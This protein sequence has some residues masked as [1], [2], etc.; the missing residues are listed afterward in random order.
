MSVSRNLRKSM[1]LLQ[2]LF[3]I[4]DPKQRLKFYI[5]FEGSLQRA[6][7]E[8]SFNLL[9]GNMDLSDADKKKLRRY[10]TM[11]RVLGNIRTKKQPFRKAISQ[12]GRG[13]AA[14]IPIAL[15]AI[16]AFT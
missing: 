13:L 3:S 6:L 7:R 1:P 15:A 4:K 2:T 9:K 12:K 10:R 8:I 11:L 16:S 5:L 14:L